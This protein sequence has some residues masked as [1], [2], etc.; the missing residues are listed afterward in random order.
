MQEYPAHHFP[1]RIE[2]AWERSTCNLNAFWWGWIIHFMK[3]MLLRG[4]GETHVSYGTTQFVLEAVESAHC[5]ALGIELT[6]ERNTCNLI[7][8][9][10]GRIIYFMKNTSLDEMGNTYILWNNT[11]CVR[12]R[13]SNTLFPTENWV[14]SRKEYCL[15]LMVS[16]VTNIIFVSNISFQVNGRSTESLVRKP[17]ML[18]AGSLAHCFHVRIELAYE[19]N[20]CDL[21]AFWS[22]R[23]IHF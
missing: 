8:F 3:N 7:T 18:E 2:L 9:W 21:K 1:M 5:F 11:T 23:I 10:S 12:G 19:R 4:N 13:R 17:C 22:W 6:C 15:P 14:L 20:T 16:R